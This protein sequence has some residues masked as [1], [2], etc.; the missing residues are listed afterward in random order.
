[1]WYDKDQLN[2]SVEGMRQGVRDHEYFLAYLTRD[3]LVRP[4]CRK[5]IRWAILYQKKIILLWKRTGN[6]SVGRFNEF[7]EATSRPIEIP[8]EGEDGG[9]SDLNAIFQDAAI[10]YYQEPPFH[11]ASMT[12]LAVRLGLRQQA[13]RVTGRHYKF[14]AKVPHKSVLWA[15][16]KRNGEQQVKYIQSQLCNFTTALAENS[17][18]WLDLQSAHRATA[19]IVFLTETVFASHDTGTFDALTNALRVGARI[20]LVAETDMAH[21]WTTFSALGENLSWNDGVE[22]LKGQV[23]DKYFEE[24]GGL[25]P[26]MFDTVNVIPFYKD[27]AFRMVSL[28]MILHALG[29]F[30]TEV[31]LDISVEQTPAGLELSAGGEET[32]SALSVTTSAASSASSLG[33]LERTFTANLRSSSAARAGSGT[34]LSGTS[35]IG[36]SRPASPGF[37]V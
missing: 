8:G 18:G 17:F 15:F 24:E 19:V 9:G 1:M 27:W 28:Q 3:Y 22:W 21:G 29:G 23:P 11:A 32:T 31:E 36:M 35:T 26:A 25:T 4:F 20:I 10:N 33:S 14:N 7:F 37:E 16:A 12:T 34:Q 6:G 2:P 5:E 30:E 13:D